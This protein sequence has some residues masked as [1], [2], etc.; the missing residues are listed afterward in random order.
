MSSGFVRVGFLFRAFRGGAGVRGGGTRGRVAHRVTSSRVSDMVVGERRADALRGDPRAPTRCLGSRA[1]SLPRCRPTEPTAGRHDLVTSQKKPRGSRKARGHP[2]SISPPLLTRAAAMEPRRSKRIKL[3]K[4]GDFGVLLG[5]LMRDVPDL[6]EAEVL[7]KLDVKDHFRLAQVNK[8]CRDVV[9]KLGPVE[10][11]RSC[12]V[13][14][15]V[16]RL[17]SG[18]QVACVE[19]RLDVLKWL[20]KDNGPYHL[21]ALLSTADFCGWIQTDIYYAG[22]HG[23]RH[24]LDWYLGFP[25]DGF[26]RRV[27][28]TLDYFEGACNGAAQGGK[29]EL[30]KYLGQKGSVFSATTCAVAARTGQL[31]VVKWLRENGCP[32]D[33]STPRIAAFHGHLSTLKWAH[34]NGCPCD[35]ATCASAALGG[36]LEILMWLRAHGCP[37]DEDTCAIAA[38]RGS[39]DL[40]QWAHENGC[41]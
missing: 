18:R 34:E 21:L 6:F 26:D 12:D 32:W 13:S 22:L 29:L 39:S 10:F 25:R 36:K 9:Y 30:L 28:Q 38:R 23:H 17:R 41:P 20:W 7:S 5:A 4:E 24:V 1:R 37:W 31:H 2:P 16:D 19:G 27:V 14:D 15:E 3:S 8:A 33:D 11:M 40:L 35:T